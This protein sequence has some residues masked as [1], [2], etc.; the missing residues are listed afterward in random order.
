[1]SSD[2]NV[3]MLPF[4][5]I[6]DVHLL[7]CLPGVY[8]VRSENNWIYVGQSV[9]IRSR[10]LAHGTRFTP[11]NSSIVHYLLADVC[12]LSNIEFELKRKLNPLAC[13][14]FAK[15]KTYKLPL[16]H[17]VDRQK[18]RLICKLSKLMASRGVA[19]TTVAGETELSASTISKLYH[20]Y[21]DRIDGKTI[22]SLCRYFDLKSIDDLFEISIETIDGS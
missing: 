19:I 3:S 4:V 18:D 10:L 12:K 21:F 8:I 14:N 17:K 9:S 15:E 1:M 5:S 7:P 11:W 2:I 13:K 6:D 16:V 22:E 20:N